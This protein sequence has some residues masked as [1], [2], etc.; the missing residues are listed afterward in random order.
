MSIV[1]P[2]KPITYHA[3]INHPSR[4]PYFTVVTSDG[5]LC[6]SIEVN[7]D[8]SPEDIAAKNHS[9]KVNHHISQMIENANIAVN[10]E[11]TNVYLLT[12]KKPKM[13]EGI[14]PESPELIP[15]SKLTTDASGKNLFLYLG[16]CGN[17]SSSSSEKKVAHVI[18]Y[19]SVI[20]NIVACHK[21]FATVL[22]NTVC[23]HFNRLS[24]TSKVTKV[25]QNI[26]TCDNPNGV[27]VFSFSSSDVGEDYTVATLGAEPGDVQI[28]RYANDERNEFP[29]KSIKTITK[30]HENNNISTLAM[31]EDQTMLATGSDGGTMIRVFD[32]SGS[33]Q[34]L[35][36]EFRRGSYETQI[37]SLAFSKDNRTLACCSGNGTVHL[38]DL[39]P[40]ISESTNTTT[41]LGMFGYALSFVSSTK[42]LTAAGSFTRH[43][44]LVEPGTKM[45]CKFDEIYPGLLHVITF[46]GGYYFIY[47][48]NYSQCSPRTDINLDTA[49][50]VKRY[51]VRD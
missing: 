39:N 33:K 12:K 46:D 31:N 11:G 49:C 21:S 29:V 17:D 45:V 50:Y 3:F 44:N 34:N 22:P 42:G 4:A 14:R 2:P 30:A 24:V 16:S 23:V 36:F 15:S 40:K 5:V 6:A 13:L 7:H 48:D 18:E 35:K 27:C 32:I 41:V 28:I 10:S 26:D 25:A 43:R 47:G 37:Y 9:A 19:N 38:F 51:S 20:T 8:T 1:L